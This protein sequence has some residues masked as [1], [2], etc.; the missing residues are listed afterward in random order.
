M[1]GATTDG[2]GRIPCSRNEPHDR[3][4][5]FDAGDVDDRHDDGGVE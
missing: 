2:P 5:R 3:G 1:C 4:H